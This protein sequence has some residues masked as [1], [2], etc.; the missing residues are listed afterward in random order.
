M[1][2]SKCELWTVTSEEFA[3]VAL[4]CTMERTKS[5]HR[6]DR[7]KRL[8]DAYMGNKY[9]GSGKEQDESTGGNPPLKGQK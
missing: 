8:H 9:S 5:D 2:I 6:S 7:S 4:I 3:F 1:A